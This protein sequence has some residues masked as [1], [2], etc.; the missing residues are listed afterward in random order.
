MGLVTSAEMMSRASDGGY[1]IGAFTINNME[2]AQG[3]ADAAAEARCAV[4]LQLSAN[5]LRYARPAYLRR[6]AEAAA[7]DTGLPICV[8][9]DHGESYEMCVECIDQGFTSVMIDASA[10]PFEDNI[11]E[12]RRV[13]QYARERGVVV[14]AELGRLAGVEDHVDV[15]ADDA[16]YTD[17][18]QA[19]EFIERTGCDSLAVAIGTSHGPVKFQGEPRLAFDRLK[20]MRAHLP[21][22]PFVLHGASSLLPEQVAACNQY[23]GAIAQA[24]GVPEPLLREAARNGICK[25][26]TDTDLRLAFTTAI[27]KHFAEQPAHFDPR[28]YLTVARAAVKDAAKHRMVNVFG[29][30]GTL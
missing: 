25:I 28:Q 6:I 12:T 23:G 4:I 2:L 10:L 15:N 19:V 1:A 3:V 16:I 18:D 24:Q 5:G 22:Y 27:R 30:A 26:N 17:P 9:L 8:H 21:R 29:C 11:R 7:D 20:R 13:V 14:E